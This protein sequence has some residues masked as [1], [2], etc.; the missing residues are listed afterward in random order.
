MRR[1]QRFSEE[2]QM[3]QMRQRVSQA[4]PSQALEPSLTSRLASHP[5][6]GL[7]DLMDNI[8]LLFPGYITQSL[9]SED[10]DRP[11]VCCVLC[12]SCEDCYDVN[13]V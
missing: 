6:Y 3:R 11:G 1:S 2:R 12:D 7:P 5:Q 10:R 8:F 13:T 9:A 4:S